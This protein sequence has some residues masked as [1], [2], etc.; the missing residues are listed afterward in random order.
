MRCTKCILEN[1]A[2]HL[3]YLKTD[4]ILHRPWVYTPGWA[5]GLMDERRTINDVLDCTFSE[6]T[7][8][9]TL[10]HLRVLSDGMSCLQSKAPNEGTMMWENSRWP[11]IKGLLLI[12]LENAYT[13]FPSLRPVVN[14][15]YRNLLHLPNYEDLS[16]GDYV[17]TR[18]ASR[19]EVC[20]G[21]PMAR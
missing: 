5:S 12:P 9:R 17:T 10:E 3:K 2:D 6:E 20:S 13:L 18:T 8:T 1:L 16:Q 7:W 21:H 4:I 19:S 15:H 14:L 11:G